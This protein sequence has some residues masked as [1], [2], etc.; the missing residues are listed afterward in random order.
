MDPQSHAE[1]SLPVL[2]VDDDPTAVHLLVEILRGEHYDVRQSF[3]P[4]QALEL[5]RH[6]PFAAII[7]DQ[8]MPRLTGLELLAQVK[9]LQPD[10]SR[11]LVTGVVDVSTVVEAV[12]R[13]EV[14]RFVVKPWLRAELL[15]TVRDAMQ[16]HELIRA[17]AQLQIATHEANRRLAEV[18]RTLEATL[19]REREEHGQFSHLN[20]AL[21][22]HVQN[23]S[24]IFESVVALVP[25]DQR[26]Q[27]R[28][29]WQSGEFA[30]DMTYDAKGM[31]VTQTR[32][33]TEL[34]PPVAE[35]MEARSCGGGTSGRPMS[36]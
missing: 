14:Y 21:S 30:T 13:G 7:S 28:Q 6:E 29:Q 35:T 18:N 16:R 5:I 17:N 32:L 27:L 33:P 24:H 12:N 11:V 25:E 4:L 20:R 22:Q 10:V 2:V 15:A 8:K 34:S 31:R 3:D 19:A 9:A 23:L 26:A 36:G 1:T